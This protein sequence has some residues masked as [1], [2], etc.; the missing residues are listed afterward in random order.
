MDYK[1]YIASPGGF[2]HEQDTTKSVLS[3]LEGRYETATPTNIGTNA[4]TPPFS[5][6]GFSRKENR[7]VASLKNNNTAN[8]GEVIFG[9]SISG[10]KGFFVEVKVSTDNTTQVGGMKEL[11]SVSSNWAL[12]SQ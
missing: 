2:E 8:P 12:S 9:N 4:V 11:F 5:Y 7:Y 6:A 1:Y 10:I 3:Y